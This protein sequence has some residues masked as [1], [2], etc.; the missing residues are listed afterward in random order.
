MVYG[1]RVF[2][3]TAFEEEGDGRDAYP[4]NPMVIAT[5]FPTTAAK[6]AEEASTVWPP[7][8]LT[9]PFGGLRKSNTNYIYLFI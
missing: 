8:P 4:R 7:A 1:K 9:I 2:L 5:P 3:V 6:F